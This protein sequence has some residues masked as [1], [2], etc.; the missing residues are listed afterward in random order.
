MRLSKSQGS[1]QQ[2]ALRH[3]PPDAFKLPTLTRAELIPPVGGAAPVTGRLQG[4]PAIP[5][6]TPP[7]AQRT[8]FPALQRRTARDAAFHVVAAAAAATTAAA[9]ALDTQVRMKCL[10]AMSRQRHRHRLRLPSPN[11]NVRNKDKRRCLLN[12]LEPNQL[13]GHPPPG[14]T[15]QLCRGGGSRRANGWAQR[16]PL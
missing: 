5:L 15:L 1:A 8:F 14:N 6:C 3:T 9:G 4:R 16:A 2:N 7:N 10:A 11:E 13:G 12:L